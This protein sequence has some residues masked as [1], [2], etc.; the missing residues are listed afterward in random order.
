M[1]PIFG[2]LTLLFTCWML[3][4]W[5]V[6]DSHEIKWMRKW[7]AIIFVGAVVLI[8]VGGTALVTLKLT[9][10]KQRDDVRR[11]AVAL[12]TRLREGQR[13][14]V[15]RQL[16]RVVDPPDEWSDESGDVLIRMTNAT[17]DLI[18]PDFPTTEPA[19]DL[20]AA[21]VR[22]AAHEAPGLQ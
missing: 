1:Y 17:S 7:G 20:N 9:M 22:T 6:G 14:E 3:W 13:E 16:Q 12:E 2:V 4:F 18:G 19:G 11:F 21:T 15:L 5:L 8:S 10:R